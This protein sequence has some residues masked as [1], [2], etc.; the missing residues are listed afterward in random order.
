MEE[1]RVGQA[2]K[3]EGALDLGTRITFINILQLQLQLHLR[4]TP[5]VLV[6]QDLR[7][8]IISI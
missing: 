1:K 4:I 2:E 5:G 3:G 7:L 8:S 6:I